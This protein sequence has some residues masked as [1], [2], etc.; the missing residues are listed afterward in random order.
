MLETRLRP[1]RLKVGNQRARRRRLERLPNIDY[2]SEF[3]TFVP[4]Q[5]GS[6]AELKMQIRTIPLKVAK[7]G[8]DVAAVSLDPY[9]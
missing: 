1:A 4:N 2:I 9:R 7:M 3:T 8:V 5:N 6:S